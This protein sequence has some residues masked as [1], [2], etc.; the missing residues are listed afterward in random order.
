MLRSFF[1][2]LL[3]CFASPSFAQSW[4]TPGPEIEF[5]DPPPVPDGWETTKSV[6]LHVHAPPELYRVSLAMARHAATSLPALADELQ[7]PLGDTIHLFIA[8]TD[9]V[10][11]EIQPGLSPEW[12]DGTAWPER[13]AIFL[14]RPRVRGPQAHP[15]EQVLDHELVHILLG[16]AFAPE[17]PPRWLQEGM[18]QVWSGEYSPGATQTLARGMLG[19]GLFTLQELDWGFPENPQQASLAYAQSADFIA[20][21]QVEYGEEALQVLIHEMARGKTIQGAVHA[22]T[23]SYLEDVDGAWRKRLESGTPLWVNAL[24]SE[25][26]LWLAMGLLAMVLLVVARVRARRRQAVRKAEEERM[27][28]IIASLN[29]MEPDPDEESTEANLPLDCYVH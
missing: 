19:S 23:G 7:V 2:L 3:L 25:E 5:A 10:F 24:L 21:L 18:A 4:R 6:Y 16:R 17:R 12:A 8:P 27:A 11:H 22:A 20:W 13:S 28:E 1:V 9:E 14:R 29:R 26:M 15:L